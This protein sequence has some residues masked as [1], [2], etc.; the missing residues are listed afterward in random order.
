[1]DCIDNF[2]WVWR[3]IRL[4]FHTLYKSLANG[5]T[6]TNQNR[7]MQDCFRQHPDV[8]GGEFEEG[9]SPE[10]D[11]L[12]SSPEVDEPSIP[13]PLDP[14]L[15]MPEVDQS[16]VPLYT[17]NAAIDKSSIAP[18]ASDSQVTSASSSM[19]GHTGTGGE[20]SRTI[21]P[22]SESDELVPKALHDTN[23]PKEG[24]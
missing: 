10:D 6:N 22:V 16:S 11:P 17:S 19:S 20:L 14:S 12:Y 2:K 15:P 1:M 18:P 3:F 23:P 9:E 13:P 8:Y 24:V 7:S 5:C 4:L 21:K